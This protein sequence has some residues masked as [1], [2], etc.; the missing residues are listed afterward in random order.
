MVKTKLKIAFIHNAYVEYRIPFFEKLSSQYRVSFFFEWFDKSIDVNKSRFLFRFLKSLKIINNYSFSPLLFFYLLRGK[1]NLFIA[2][3]IG[4][5]N[6]YI[7]YFASILLHKPFIFWDEN[8]YLPPTS[9]RRLTW[10]FLLQILNRSKAIIVPGSKSK[11]LY[12][13]INPLLSE[14]IFVA[15]NASLLH[16]NQIT[17]IKVKN[18]RESL[19]IGDKKVILYFGRLIKQ[20]G[21]EYLAKAFEKLQQ[22]HS[23]VFLLVVGGQYGHGERYSIKELE[24]LSKVIS[25]DKIR[26]TGWIEAA[27]KT[28]YFL[29]ADVVVVPSIFFLEGSEVWG[30]SVNEAMSVGK[31]VIAT[32][33]VGAA[34]DL[35]HNGI[36]GFIVPD[37][38]P[39]ALYKAIKLVINDSCNQK[40]M[41]SK[42]LLLLKDGFTYEHMLLGFTEGISF[43]LNTS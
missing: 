6:T 10:P 43:A 27:E 3:A 20:K 4:E 37:K 17:D 22:Y 18:L 34:H 5:V 29:L 8:W 39:E 21:F 23:K 36:N 14:K 1:Y 12:L 38:N 32:K 11:E 41:G 15:P 2:G 26:F 42:S 33:A 7:A 28:T 40:T 9:W 35:I 13:S 25:P 19:K 30:F 31:P 16:P 24:N